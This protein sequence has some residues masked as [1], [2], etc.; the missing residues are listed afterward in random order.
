MQVLMHLKSE[1]FIQKIHLKGFIC[2]S[3]TNINGEHLSSKRNSQKFL[4]T[5]KGKNIFLSN[6]EL[7]PWCKVCETNDQQKVGRQSCVWSYIQK[8]Q[9]KLVW[10]WVFIF[11]FTFIFLDYEMK[12]HVLGIFSNLFSISQKMSSQL[13]L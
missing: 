2:C 1:K 10:S 6:I 4:T 7:H 5:M 3:F 12:A 13:R 8:R 11:W 9:K